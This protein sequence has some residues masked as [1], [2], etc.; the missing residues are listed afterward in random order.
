MAYL[1]VNQRYRKIANIVDKK[2]TAKAKVEQIVLEDI[3]V[4][5]VDRVNEFKKVNKHRGT[6]LL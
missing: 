3:V 5:Q 1:I 2:F 4:D 6:T